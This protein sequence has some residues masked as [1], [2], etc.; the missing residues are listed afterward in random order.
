MQKKFFSG[1]GKAMHAIQYSKPEMYN[2]AQDLSHHMHKAMQDHFK[3]MLHIL[4]YSLD[5]VE[6]GLVRKANRDWDGSQSHEFVISG[7]SDLDYAK[8][9]KDRLS[10]SRHVVYLEGAPAM[11]KSST[12]KA[13]SLSTTKA[14]THAGVTWV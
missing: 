3:A 9:P 4:K 13:V 5:T 7:R 12:E 11:F 6:Q 2:A 10:V 8:E 14:G 1:T